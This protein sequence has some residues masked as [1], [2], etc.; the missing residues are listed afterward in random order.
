MIKN[1]KKN[2]ICNVNVGLLLPAKTVWLNRCFTVWVAKKGS[3][4]V[5]NRL[6]PVS[7]SRLL[8]RSP[9]ETATR[10]P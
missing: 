7:A 6:V 10:F 8:S 4:L 5:R 1:V 2:N 9:S 3:F